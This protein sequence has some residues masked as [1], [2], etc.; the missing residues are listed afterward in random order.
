MLEWIAMLTM[1]VDHLGFAF[2]SDFPILRAIGRIA[3]P[4]YCFFIVLGM[5]RTRNRKRYFKRLFLIAI[6]SQVPYNLVF[7]EI[8]LNVVFVLLFG[9]ISIWVYGT[10]KGPMKWLLLISISTTI[11]AFSDYM[12]YG[13][14]GIMLCLLYYFFKEKPIAF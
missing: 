10:C 13:I 1:L 3:F 2:F 14:Y 11:L 9:A 4:L 8:Q 7:K 5:E 12:S 6:L